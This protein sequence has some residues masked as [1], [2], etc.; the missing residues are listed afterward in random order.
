MEIKESFVKGKRSA[1]LCEDGVVLTPHFV[2][3]VDGSTSKTPFHLSP[4]MKNGRFAMTIISNFIRLMPAD[5][6]CQEFCQGVT[7]RIA[8]E[9]KRT[10]LVSRMAEHPEERL[11]ASAIV[12]SRE[13]REVWMV[14]DCQA[15][16]D[17]VPHDNAKPDEK[18]IARRR[19]ELILGGMSP[20]DARRTIEPELI[21]GMKEGQ[22]RHYA[23]ID[24]TLVYMPGVKILPVKSS[25]VLAS[26]GYPRLMLTLAESEKALAR[27]IERDPQNVHYFLATKGIVEGNCSFDDRAFVSITV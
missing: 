6:T 13:R 1:E 21:K 26:D 20:Q 19:A 22:N 5:A 10:G 8:E 23:V 7:L 11:C 2:A 25:A 15:I 3:V 27:Q 12:F 9:Y 24:G 4:T 17:G 18:R 14:G 16:I